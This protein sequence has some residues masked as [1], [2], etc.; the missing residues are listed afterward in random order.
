[1]TITLQLLSNHFILHPSGAIYWK[2]KATLLIADVHLGKVAHFR[3]YGSA[4]PLN[5]SN[6]NFERLNNVIDF[7]NPQQ[8]CFLGDLFHSSINKDW[9]FFEDWVSKHYNKRIYL[10]AG[11]HDIISPLKYEEL[12]IKIVSEWVTNQ[13]LFTHYPDERKNLFNFSGHIHPAVWLQGTGKQK[14]KLACF[15]KTKN[16]IIL[17]A[18]GV[19]TGKFV[20]EPKITDQIFVVTKEEVIEIS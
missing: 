5:L 17:P 15:F 19:F 20:L 2:E 9:L 11:N 1:M 7:F 12:Q 13:F 10:I 8:I 18:F 4:V 3:K 14:L 6:E 16:Q